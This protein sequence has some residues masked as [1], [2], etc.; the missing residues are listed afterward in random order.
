M[1]KAAPADA[2]YVYVVTRSDLPQPHSQVQVAHAAIA[3]T[4]AYGSSKIPHPHLVVCVVENEEELE[5]A[6]EKLKEQGI[7]V[8]SWRE[9]DMGNAL[10]AISTG[11][12]AGSS[13][14]PMRR[15]RLMK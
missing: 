5:A 3:A 6:F 4:L 10:T 15:F 7:P 14:K 11:P 2:R 8:I 1:K 13:R 9:D 12:L